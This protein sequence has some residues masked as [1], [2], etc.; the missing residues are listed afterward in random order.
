MASLAQIGHLFLSIFQK[1]PEKF[2]K[3]LAEKSIVT[4]ML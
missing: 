4:T 3:T 2:A 1:C